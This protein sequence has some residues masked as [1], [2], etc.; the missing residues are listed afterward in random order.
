MHWRQIKLSTACIFLEW[1]A[2]QE[3]DRAPTI[4]RRVDSLGA[5]PTDMPKR[6]LP[7]SAM[8]ARS[9]RPPFT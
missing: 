5:L 6:V 4:A 7:A 2:K 8:R 3:L 1:H 9:T